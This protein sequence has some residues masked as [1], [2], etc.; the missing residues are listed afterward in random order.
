MLKHMVDIGVTVL[1][2][3]NMCF[4]ARN[5]G[6]TRDAGSI[7]FVEVFRLP[8]PPVGSYQK[9]HSTGCCS[10]FG[11]RCVNVEP[12]GS[13][14][15]S[16]PPLSKGVHVLHTLLPQCSSCHAFPL[17]HPTPPFLRTQ[18]METSWHFVTETFRIWKTVCWDAV[19]VGIKRGR[20][21]CT[22]SWGVCL[23]EEPWT[24]GL[25]RERQEGEMNGTPFRPVTPRVASI[26]TLEKE[27]MPYC[28]TLRSDDRSVMFDRNVGRLPDCT[29]VCPS[30]YNSD[31]QRQE[32][33]ELME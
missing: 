1:W 7:Q 24:S 33:R 12:H 2:G 10:Y 26:L 15:F 21:R 27:T 6:A 32:Q 31:P 5:N 14:G 16:P 28:L 11:V 25:L 19:W 18:S 22:D 9:P 3:T 8:Q 23:V 29:I 30:R 17:P 20:G 13:E 4:L